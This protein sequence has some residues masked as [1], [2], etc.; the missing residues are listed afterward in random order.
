MLDIRD[1]NLSFGEKRVLSGCSLSL[2][3][4]ERL[5]HKRAFGFFPRILAERGVV[6]HPVKVC[7]ERTFARD[8]T[9]P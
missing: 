5:A 8:Y 9:D 1:V 4:G 2:G 6:E 3:A 7:A